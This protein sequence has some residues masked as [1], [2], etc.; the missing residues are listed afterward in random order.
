[1][2][3]GSLPDCIYEYETRNRIEAELNL[4]I[5]KLSPRSNPLTIM[6][7]VVLVN[8]CRLWEYD[9]ECSHIHELTYRVGFVDILFEPA[10]VFER[11]FTCY[12]LFD[13]CTYQFDCFVDAINI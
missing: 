6:H 2:F 11:E 4:L 9:K 5:P 12:I 3:F 8:L 1:M 13:L 7:S 10:I